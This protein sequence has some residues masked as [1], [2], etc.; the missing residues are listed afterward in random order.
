MKST[1]PCDGNNILLSSP[2]LFSLIFFF[3]RAE[4][5]IIRLNSVE[6]VSSMSIKLL[7]LFYHIPEKTS[8]TVLDFRN[9]KQQMPN[10][11]HD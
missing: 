9:A 4:R 3:T 6:A 1:T 8:V 2:A 10:G 11:T 5:S 7:L